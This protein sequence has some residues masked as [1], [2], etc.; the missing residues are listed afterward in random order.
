MKDEKEGVKEIE[1]KKEDFIDSNIL[2]V[3]ANQDKDYSKKLSNALISCYK[4]HEDVS[5]K[6][7]G[8]NACNNAI[9]AIEKSRPYLE[10]HDSILVTEVIESKIQLKNK[11]NGQIMMSK[12]FSFLPSLIDGKVEDDI[13]DI[14]KL[15]KIKGFCNSR[16]ENRYYI[17]KLSN[18]IC[19]CF[20][21]HDVAFLRYVGVFAGMNAIEAIVLARGEM[22]K[23]GINLGF[24]PRSVNIRF[25]KEEKQGLVLEIVSIEK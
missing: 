5:L 11:N 23:S 25:D 16:E 1:G 24:V 21:K 10:S 6:C 18:A 15:L 19:S 4:I 13:F 22:F 20:L 9:Y 8:G 3:S 14:N 12:V 17:E 2:F 7:I